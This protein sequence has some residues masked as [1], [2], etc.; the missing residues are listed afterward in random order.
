MSVD[1]SLV[2]HELLNEFQD[3]F[4]GD[5]KLQQKLHLEADKS[6][7]PVVLPVRKVPFAL[8]ETLREEQDRLVKKGI[9]VPVDAPMD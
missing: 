8:K 7:P 5:G 3:V 4:E 6:I 2:H 1:S 9:L